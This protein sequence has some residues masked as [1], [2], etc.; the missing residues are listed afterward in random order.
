MAVITQIEDY[1]SKGCGRCARF[2][3]LDCATRQ[4]SEGLTEL[5]RICI[6][7][8]LTETVK[9]GH[10]CYMFG[11]RNIALIGAF[12]D[13]FRLNFMNASLM[14]DPQSVLERRGPATRHADMIRFIDNAQVLK[15]EGIIADYLNEA[16]GYAQAAIRSPKTIHEIELPDALIGA[17]VQDPE[18]ADA[19]HA[20]TAGRQ[21]SYVL[22]LA[23]TE[24]PATQF[25]RIAK[26]RGKVMA[27]KGVNER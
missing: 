22:H 19:F 24:N 11:D 27:G 26:F 14:R 15:M 13:N 8:D 6:Q 7:A 1:F 10:P 4:W 25:A 21:R 12:R 2:A 20:L 5:R 23:T 3:T 9:W 18:L 16:I 17:L